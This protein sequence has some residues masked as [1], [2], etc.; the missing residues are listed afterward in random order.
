MLVWCHLYLSVSVLLE[1]VRVMATTE[2]SSS[3]SRELNQMPT[4]AVAGVCVV[5]IIISIVLENFLHKLGTRLIKRHKKALFEAL[6]KVKAEL[7]ILGFISP[8]LTF[9]Q[10]YIARICLPIKVLKNMLP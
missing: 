5:I 7:M 10:S 6:K 9:G 1:G 4:W 8:L 3:Y 2:S